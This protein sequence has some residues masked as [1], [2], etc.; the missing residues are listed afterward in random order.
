MN[1]YEI[2]VDLAPGTTDLEFTHA[3]QAYLGMLQNE[4]KLE[5]FRIRRRKL[6]F[7]PAELGEWNISIDFTGL[8]QVD[9]AF[10]AA[11][12]RAGDLEELHFAVY[13]RVR[14]FRSALYRDFPDPVRVQ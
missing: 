13:S 12:R 3:V 2:W 14:N 7:G 1:T 4:G 11:A 5:R 6:G 10:G 9:E 8:A